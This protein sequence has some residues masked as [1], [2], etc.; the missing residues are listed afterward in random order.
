MCKEPK[1]LELEQFVQNNSGHVLLV[2]CNQNISTD[3]LLI[4]TK[5]IQILEIFFKF[6]FF[7]WRFYYWESGVAVGGLGVH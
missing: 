6:Y 2:K 1:A 7:V 5:F 3:D 4:L